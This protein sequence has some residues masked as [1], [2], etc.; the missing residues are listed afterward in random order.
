ME[1]LFCGGVLLAALVQG[2]YYPT[3]FLLAAVVFGVAAALRTKG[4]PRR[5]LLAAWCFSGW[6]LLASLVNGYS[7]S[8]LA[9]AC[10]P[11]AVCAA[12]S[13][14]VSLSQEKRRR[15]LRLLICASAVLAGAGILAFGG[16]LP[17]STAVTAHRLQF[18][19]QYA[20]AAGSWYAALAL[21]AQED[22]EEEAPW[23][24]LSLQ[25]A[26]IL[27]RSIGALGLYVLAQ[28]VCL[29]RNRGRPHRWQSALL[30]NMAAMCFALGFYLSPSPWLA[31]ALMGALALASWRLE[32]LL[33]LGRRF[34]LYWAVIPAI[35]AALP[36][37]GLSR[38][39][40][41]LATFVERGYQIWDGLGILADHPL[42]GL[43]AGGWAYAYPLRQSAEYV[44]NVVHSGVVQ[45]GVDAG[46]PAILLAGLFFAL[47]WRGAR[48]PFPVSLASALLIL[49]SL[50]D[51]NLQF[52]PLAV[53][54][55]FL[56]LFSAPEP[57]DTSSLH[58]PRRAGLL[59]FAALCAVLLAGEL[60]YKQLIYSAQR[61]ALSETLA[62][63]ETGARWFGGSV[64]ARS[65]AA[66]AAGGLGDWDTVLA[67]TRE[68]PPLTSR[69]VLLRSQ[70]LYESQGRDA[71][72][73]YLLD[74]LERRPFQVSLYEDAALLLERW[75]GGEAALARYNAL[76]RRFNQ[77][78]T[79]LTALQGADRVYI[80]EIS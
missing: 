65:V 60:Q 69:Q 67:L 68:P 29:I 12:L 26:L 44:S 75:G 25:T 9:Q 47:A 20:N 18:P 15:A 33:A 22:W 35:A 5:A 49:H 28:L 6:Y 24:L 80:E 38:L 34:R 57:P 7:L 73:G 2:G 62:R 71:A 23:P 10:L 46:V 53:L 32:Q 43:G 41:G 19:F 56:L 11:G 54:A 13:C 17:I 59:A 16:V 64:D 21:I 45:F 72:C 55:G 36:V 79:I 74:E 4:P 27:T 50:V 8:S 63:Y 40:R 30:S 39:A 77:T 66:S 78:Q 14:A 61:G 42:F 37:M 58:R 70:G 76:A 48:R 3:V 31:A 1:Y 52:F 51:F